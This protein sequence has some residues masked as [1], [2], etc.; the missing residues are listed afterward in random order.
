MDENE[1]KIS[2]EELNEYYRKRNAYITKIVTEA[3]EKKKNEKT[4]SERKEKELKFLKM[5]CNEYK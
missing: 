1:K 4:E 5:L 3:E 2:N